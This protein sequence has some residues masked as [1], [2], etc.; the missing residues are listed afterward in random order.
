MKSLGVTI[1]AVYKVQKAVR[2][3]VRSNEGNLFSRMKGNVVDYDT[4]AA[5]A[6][7]C[8]YCI[9]MHL[10]TSNKEIAIVDCPISFKLDIIMM[11]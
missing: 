10:F 8:N 7:G 6:Y 1:L 4:F 9:K 3:K 5:C 2:S 11:I